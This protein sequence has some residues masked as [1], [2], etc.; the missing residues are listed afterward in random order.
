MDM[1]WALSLDGVVIIDDHGV[2]RQVMVSSMEPK[3]L[4]ANVVS[5]VGLL[6]KHKVSSDDFVMT[7]VQPLADAKLQLL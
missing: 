4:A 5:L 7:K 3:D 1:N 6:K 2:I